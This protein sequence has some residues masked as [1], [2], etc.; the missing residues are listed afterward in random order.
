MESEMELEQDCQR[1]ERAVV[2]ICEPE[3]VIVEDVEFE[4]S[5]DSIDYTLCNLDIS[6]AVVDTESEEVDAE[7]LEAIS[8]IEGKKSFPCPKCTKICKSKGGLTK[9]T[10]SKH[11]DAVDLPSSTTKSAE[12]ETRLSEENLAS[13]VEDIKRKLI[14]EDLFGSGINSALKKVSSSKALFDAVLPIYNQFCRKKNQDKMLEDFYGLLPIN[15]NA[16]LNCTDGKVANLIMIEIPDRLVGFFKVARSREEASS[17]P[18]PSLNSAVEIDPSERG[19]LSYI[20]GYIVSKMHQKSRNRKDTCSEE[21]QALVRSLKSSESANNFISARSRGG[22]VA[23]CE[24]LLGIL[25]EAEIS[26]RKHVGIGDLA[27]TVRNIPV[28]IICVSTLNSPLVKS[29]WDNIVLDS[30]V[31]KSCSTQKL[32]LENI[33]K[34][35]LRVRSF[36]YAKDY[37]SKYKIKGKQAKSKAIRKDLKRRKDS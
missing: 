5:I 12:Q 14:K 36:S 11:R 18:T 19:P 26:F 21:L 8:E 2:E 16:F 20:A 1:H 37:I 3:N 13:I 15:P 35:Y 29:L 4:T 25:E 31:G 32:L 23:P 28:D 34:L 27:D 17:N 33:V 10:N 30:G 22:L 7:F 9:H 24:G 6:V